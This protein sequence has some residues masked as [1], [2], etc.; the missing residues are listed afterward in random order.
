MTS[1]DL[2]SIAASL[3]N[4]VFS[5]SPSHVVIFSDV[6][7][8]VGAYSNNVRRRH[9]KILDAKW[10]NIFDTKERKRLPLIQHAMDAGQ[11]GLYLCSTK[12]A[13]LKTFEAIY[14]RLQ[15][16]RRPDGYEYHA[17]EADI[18]VVRIWADL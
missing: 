17:I 18:V 10:N 16:L 7:I 15:T 12:E 9:Q 2:H 3:V 13:A 6:D 1:S 4:D 14:R 8:A 11:P 5:A